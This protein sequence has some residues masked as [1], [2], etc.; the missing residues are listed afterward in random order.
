MNIAI[1]VTGSRCVD[2]LPWNAK[3]FDAL[4]HFTL[5][6]ERI[7][8]IHGACPNPKTKRGERIKS[9]SIDM[10][11]HKWASS[12]DAGENVIEMAFPADWKLGRKAGP[13]RNVL[14]V[15]TLRAL[16]DSGHWF[17][18]VLAFHPDLENSSGTRHTVQYARKNGFQVL[19]NDGQQSE[20]LHAR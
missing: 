18:C 3:V 20:H 15:D 13:I 14:M 16:T 19:L 9:V 17:E 11:A 1:L 12:E 5:G 8:V 10:L 2:L 7:I 4:N 6:A